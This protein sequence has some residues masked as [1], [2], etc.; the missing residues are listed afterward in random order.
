MAKESAGQ[1][2]GGYALEGAGL[3]N[4]RLAINGLDHY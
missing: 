1:R 4:Q 3:M 2:W